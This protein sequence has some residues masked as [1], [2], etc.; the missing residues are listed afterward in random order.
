MEDQVIEPEAIVE[1][2]VVSEPIVEEAVAENPVVISEP[3][4]EEVIKEEKPKKKAEG[5]VD[6]FSLKAVSKPG[7]PDIKGGINKLSKS[8]ADAWMAL[9]SYI[10]L[11][12][13]DK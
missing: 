13:G 4:I 3:A 1:N 7:L 6:V 11:Y 2:A 9:K 5:L 10:T 8:D 12:E